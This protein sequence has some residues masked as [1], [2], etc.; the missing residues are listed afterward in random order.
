[1]YASFSLVYYVFVMHHKNRPIQS[2]VTPVYL[3]SLLIII[4]EVVG[5]FLFYAVHIRVGI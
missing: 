4:A 2:I 5:R 1:V 3:S